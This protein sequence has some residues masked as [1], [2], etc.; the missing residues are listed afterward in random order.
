M[1]PALGL[2]WQGMR[3][4]E[5]EKNINHFSDMLS[6]VKDRLN[7]FFQQQKNDKEGS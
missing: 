3:Q 6:S 5:G 4:K 7:F 2:D 1:A